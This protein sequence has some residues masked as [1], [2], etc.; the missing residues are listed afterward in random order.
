MPV[1]AEQLL[2]KIP[3]RE[4]YKI[5]EAIPKVHEFGY[6]PGFSSIDENEY[7]YAMWFFWATPAERAVCCLLA[8]LPE[9]VKVQQ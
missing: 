9:K 4:R 1:M 6:T 5:F 3:S 8:L 2:R 7:R